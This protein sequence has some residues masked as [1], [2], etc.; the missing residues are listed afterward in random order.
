MSERQRYQPSPRLVVGAALIAV[1]IQLPLTYLGA[2][3]PMS[4]DLY[5]APLPVGESGGLALFGP[6]TS[7]SPLFWLLNV[8]ITTAVIYLILRAG[9]PRS[10][11]WAA[12]WGVVAVAVSYAMQLGVDGRALPFAGLPIPASMGWVADGR[13]I[14]LIFLADAIAC[15]A[16]YVWWR[17]HRLAR[18]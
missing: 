18:Q 12:V 7:F 17:R 9:A 15:S 1:L 4:N 10:A 8:V 3:F 16:A 2:V 13:P 5:G 14:H 11:V 6:S